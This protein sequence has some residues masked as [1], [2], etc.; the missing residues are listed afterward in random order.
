MICILSFFCSLALSSLSLSVSFCPIPPVI[1]TSLSTFLAAPLYQLSLCLYP[2]LPSNTIPCSFFFLSCLVFF[3]S[4]LFFP[5]TATLHLL[6]IFHSLLC[7]FSLFASTFFFLFPLSLSHFIYSLLP[8]AS[9]HPPPALLLCCSISN[10]FVQ[11]FS[12][13][14]TLLSLLV[15]L[16]LLTLLLLLID[17]Y[18]LAVLPP[19]VCIPYKLHPSYPT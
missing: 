16:V 1:P 12:L 17:L 6:F 14:L 15:C 19:A 10:T 13:S 11:Q 3:H 8:F 2:L 7:S 4:L 5:L 18:R 9:F